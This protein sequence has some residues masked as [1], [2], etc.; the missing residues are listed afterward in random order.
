VNAPHAVACASG[1]AALH[2]ALVASS[3]QPDDEV[4]VPAL[5]F[6][7]PANAV[8]YVSAWPS[9]V[10]VDPD[11]WQIDP[12]EVRAFLRDD[13]VSSEGKLRNRLTGRRVSAIVAVDN[14]GH[15]CDLDRLHAIAAEFGLALIE[16]ATESLGA[17]YHGRPLGSITHIAAFSFNGNKLITTG[18]GGMIATTDA[19]VAERAR[20][21]TTQAKDDAIEFVH[22]S[23]GYNYR[24]TNVQAAI[25]CAQLEQL[26]AFLEAKRTIARR[27]TEALAAIPG[28]TTMTEAPWA[29][30]AFWMFTVLVDT[31]RAGVDSRH[32]LRALNMEGIETR[33]LWQPLHQ[34]PA[35]RQSFARRCPV[36][37]SL[38]ARA[39]CLPCSTGLTPDQQDAVIDAIRRLCRN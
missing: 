36:A 27:Y 7:A 38:H 29:R 22:G 9:F 39:L 14:L 28:I 17:H 15:P 35:H 24:L 21:L 6:I 34:S 31:T 16:D 37:E 26:T 1:T 30:S 8:R 19:A 25:G 10:D 32:L 18:G 23:I 33:P 11:Y 4:I 13:C 20:Y 3:V 12:S 2:T 5:T